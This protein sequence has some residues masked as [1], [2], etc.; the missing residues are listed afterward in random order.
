MNFQLLANAVFNMHM[1]EVR[2][3]IVFVI[4]KISEEFRVGVIDRVQARTGFS[5]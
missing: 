4:E 5:E 2:N 1:I 3:D